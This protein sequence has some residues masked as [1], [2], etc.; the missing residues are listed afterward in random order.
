MTERTARGKLW[1]TRETEVDMYVY[2]GELNIGLLKKGRK[3]TNQGAQMW[4]ISV[5]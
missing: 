4:R 3:V 1:A 5:L 2:S